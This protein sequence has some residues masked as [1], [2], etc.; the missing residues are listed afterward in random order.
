MKPYVIFK[1]KEVFEVTDG[2]HSVK[3][4]LTPKNVAIGSPM[5]KDDY[6]QEFIFASSRDKKTLARWEAITDLLSEAVKI[7]K[8]KNQKFHQ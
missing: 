2:D 7:L 6:K 5:C 4:T 3:I 1:L 8:V